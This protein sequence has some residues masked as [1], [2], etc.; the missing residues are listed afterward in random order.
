MAKICTNTA[1]FLYEIPDDL[2][3]ENEDEIYRKASFIKKTFINGGDIFHLTSS[4]LSIYDTNKD[5]IGKCVNCGQWTTNREAD[6]SIG[7]ICNGAVVDGKLLCDD[8]L[9]KGHRW[10]F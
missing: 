8:C 3:Y 2:V 9:P 4:V 7:S 1:T 10:A 6:N 5:N